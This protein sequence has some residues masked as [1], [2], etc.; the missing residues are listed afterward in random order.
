MEKNMQR[1][2]KLAIVLLAVFFI[3]LAPLAAAE[4]TVSWEWLLDDPD[5]TA[6]RYQLGGEDPDNWTV[7][8]ADTNTYEVTGLD[9]YQSYTLY[10]Q[11]T[12]DGVNWSASGVSTAEALLVAEEV[13]A[14]VAEE[15]AA[16]EE[17]VPAAVVEEAPVAE[18]APAAV[19]EPVAVEEEPVAEEAVEEPAPVVVAPLAPIAPA[20]IAEKPNELARSLLIKPG[21]TFPAMQGD[22]KFDFMFDGKNNQILGEFGLA[23]DVAN[24]ARM[25][26]HFG[27]GLRTDLVAGFVADGDKPWDL[28]KTTDYFDINNYIGD[29]SLDL[30]LM[31][32]VTAGPAVIYLGAGAGLE[33][34]TGKDA[35]LWATVMEGEYNV[36]TMKDSSFGMNYFLSGIVGVRFY[37]GD[38]FS[39]G[40][41]GGYKYVPSKDDFTNGMHL[42]SGD[43][44]LGFTF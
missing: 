17:V 26:D 14:A 29:V 25:G 31:L 12:Y 34:P 43:I 11:R 27:I 2:R 6:Y 40:I 38:V 30:K 10:L 36:F 7:V 33:I 35:S 18:E 44:L 22:G 3:G 41:E 24:L 8:S 23:F 5:V 37:M 13:P 16:E 4:M 15:P 32:D 1:I 9:P 19:E 39:L 42:F 20:E 28:A 21:V